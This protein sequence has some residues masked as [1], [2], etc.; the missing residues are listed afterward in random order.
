[1]KTS[2]FIYFKTKSKIKRNKL[3]FHDIRS[4]FARPQ[5]II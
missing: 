1:M 4:I 5:E 3:H 2:Y